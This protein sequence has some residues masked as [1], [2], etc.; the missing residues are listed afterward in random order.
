MPCFCT[1]V[2]EIL[3]WITAGSSPGLCG[4][5][6]TGRSSVCISRGCNSE[7]IKF[8]SPSLSAT[9][10]L[11]FAFFLLPIEN[12]IWWFKIHLKK[13]KNLHIKREKL[14]CTERFIMT[15]CNVG[16]VCCFSWYFP[17]W[18]IQL[19]KKRILLSVQQNLERRL[20]CQ[21]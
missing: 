17:R 11:L 4:A 7:I 1:N 13:K 9:I 15:E 20:A 8:F 3:R 10:H 2:Y 21:I 18:S 12:L 19:K 5:H 6:G 16:Y 14:N